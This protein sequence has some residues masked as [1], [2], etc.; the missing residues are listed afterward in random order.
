MFERSVKNKFIYYS[1]VDWTTVKIKD[2]KLDMSNFASWFSCDEFDDSN[3]VSWQNKNRILLR[4]YR[5]TNKVD[6]R[7]GLSRK[8]CF[9]DLKPKWKPKMILYVLLTDLTLKEFIITTEKKLEE[10]QCGKPNCQYRARPSKIENHRQ[11]CRDYTIIKSKQISYGQPV[12]SMDPLFKFCVFDIETVEQESENENIEATLS[13]LSIGVA[14]NLDGMEKRYF[15]RKS[16]QPGTGQQLVNEFMQYLFQL[17]KRHDLLLPEKL[18]SD[19]RLILKRIE[20]CDSWLDKKKLYGEKAK[21][22]SL[23]SMPVFG[24]NSA[25]FDLKCLVPFMV[26][27]ANENNLGKKVKVLKKGGKYFSFSVDSLDFKDVLSFSAPCSLETYFDQ[28]YKGALAKGIFPYQKFSSVEE[29]NQQVNF[30]SYE[31]FYS[32]LKASNVNIREYESSRNEYQR[33]IQLPE[34][35]PDKMNNFGCWLKHYQML[36]VVPLVSAIENCFKTFYQHFQV[37]PMEMKSLP[38]IAFSAAFNLF[39][40]TM[41]YIYSFS[42]EFDSVRQLFRNNQIGGLVNIFHRHVNLVDQTGPLSSRFAPNG[43]QFSFFSFWDFNSLYLWA[44]D[45]PMPL[46]PG[47]LWEKTK[48]SFS[49]KPM[50]QGVSRSELEWL[51]WLQNEPFC[52]DKKG[53]RQRITHAFYQGQKKVNGKPVD[54]WLE[55]DGKI[56]LLEFYGCRWHPD[57]CV[58]DEK[59]PQAEY[60]RLQDKKKQEEM[61]EIGEIIIMRE[62]RWREIKRSIDKSTTELG[63]IMNNDTEASLLEAIRNEEVFGFIVAD[64]ETSKDIID[65]FG[66]FLFPPVIQRLDV[67]SHMLS[68]YMKKVCKDEGVFIDDQEPTI[69]QTYNCKQQ[70]LL[71]SM[72]KLYLDRGMVVSNITKFIQVGSF[73][74]TSLTN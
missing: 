18:I 44:Q 33:R 57:C 7:D 19:Y 4:F 48:Y 20:L 60:R 63:R 30:P 21:L 34:S 51:M 56:Y 65:S 73:N 6:Y 13:I 69:V 45:Q 67:K 41:P 36:D 16:S 64:V 32:D 3:F 38:S 40:Q 42:Q 11:N 47:L 53:E 70:L 31:S 72:V 17:K 2:V 9:G 8:N 46:T 74:M 23:I 49:K 10:I 58:S 12:N 5:T 1:Y 59:I 54:G 22:Q 61:K 43:Q 24:F 62:C 28:W 25:K 15:V 29:I 14:T 55:K 68:S 26:K 50:T 27:Y 52:V 39:D 35:D 66:S 71:T 37:N